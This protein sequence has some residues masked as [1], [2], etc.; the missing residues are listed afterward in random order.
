[1]RFLVLWLGLLPAATAASFTI[2]G[3][4][5]DPSG[6]AIAGAQVSVVN[7]LG[8]ARQT[9][10]DQAGG[11]TLKLA[12]AGDMHLAVTAPGFETKNIPL[13]RT[14]G[15]APLS[16]QGS[17]I[18]IVPREEIAERNEG[19]AV[20]L[21]RYLPGITVAQT[22]SAG[23]VA[24]LFIRGGNYNFNLVQIDGDPVNSFGGAFDFAHIPPD[25]LAR[26]EVIEG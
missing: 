7:R 16:E 17:S 18:A 24:D 15:Q 8:V 12:Q 23:A 1:M 13:A 4:V 2:H 10:T 9:T 21:L 20:D 26:V 3:T 22:G 25:W 6:A 11:F 5:L 14:S 19:L